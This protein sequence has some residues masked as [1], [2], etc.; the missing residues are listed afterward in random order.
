MAQLFSNL[1]AWSQRLIKEV[2]STGDFAVDLT[3]G[4]GYDTLMLAQAVGAMGR[5]LA[6]DVQNKAL[7]NTASR[8]AGLGLPVR[9][10]SVPGT[11]IAAGVN[12][13]QADH[14][15][16]DAWC[17]MPPRAI[18]ANLGY[19]P[20]GD[21]TLVT[22]AE[23][24][25]AALKAACNR[26]AFGGRIAVVVYP[27]HPGGLV[28]AEAVELFFNQLEESQFEV[29]HLRVLNRPRSP[30]LLTASKQS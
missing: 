1:S 7:E 2:L 23:S 26:L 10:L 14:A 6:F 24:T 8:L 18:I 12:M 30:F 25:L 13:V 16:F 27:V 9:R 21:R 5:V 29:L 3:A 4:N 15:D 28:E 19:L 22:K 20:G 11:E 17:V